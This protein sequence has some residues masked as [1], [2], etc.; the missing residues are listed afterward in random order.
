MN[1]WT[2]LED[3]CDLIE[4]VP[5]TRIR[6]FPYG[7]AILSRTGYNEEGRPAPE[8]SRRRERTGWQTWKAT[9]RE[10]TGI[11]NLKIKYN[12]VFGYYLEVTNS[13]KDHG[14]GLLYQKADADQ[15]GA[16]YHAGIK[17]AGRYDSGRRGPAVRP[18]I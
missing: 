2:A 3:L 11:K 18:G 13:F 7:T 4:A 15:C 8:R 1:I 17:R 5:S 12:K 16:V 14:A 9:E 6:R 10:K